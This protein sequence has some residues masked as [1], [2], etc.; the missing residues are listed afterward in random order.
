MYPLHIMY[1]RIWKDMQ[2]DP[3]INLSEKAS[4]RVV[5]KV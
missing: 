4:H 3:N 2:N 1:Q 5:Y